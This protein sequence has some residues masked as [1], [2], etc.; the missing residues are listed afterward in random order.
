MDLDEISYRQALVDLE[1]ANIRILELS[2]RISKRADEL[3][4]LGSELS[5]FNASSKSEVS[6]VA[7]IESK[8]VGSKQRMQASAISYIRSVFHVSSR[9]QKSQI[10]WHLDELGGEQV[11]PLGRNVVTR[12]NVRQIS[13]SGWAVPIGGKFSFDFIEIGIIGA[14]AVVVKGLEPLERP[15][16]GAHFGN[17]LLT[18]SGFRA[19][20]SP[21]DLPN[22]IYVV[23]VGGLK[24]GRRREKASIAQIELR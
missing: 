9:R 5:S 22:G 21:E 7:R 3:T 14:A 4:K 19:H 17:K 10:L 23:E 11:S 18:R 15:D 8:K 16:V 6:E 2:A 24:E 1:I 13:I 12:S 20:F